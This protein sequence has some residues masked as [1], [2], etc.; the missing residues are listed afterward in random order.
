M[1]G[2]IL[3]RFVQHVCSKE[4]AMYRYGRVQQTPFF[5][6]FMLCNLRFTAVM[7]MLACGGW[8]VRAD[9]ASGY[10]STETMF[11]SSVASS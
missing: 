2:G 7:D 9:M 8:H 4:S 1:F 11:A 5:Q 6:L 10:R 3:V